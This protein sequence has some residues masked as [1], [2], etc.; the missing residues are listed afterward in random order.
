[1]QKNKLVR[2][3]VVYMALGIIPMASALFLAPVYTHYLKPEEYGIIALAN[4]LQTYLSLLVC[5]S[6]DAAFSRFYFNNYRDKDKTN[7]MLSNTLITILI[8]TVIT[9]A[10][11]YFTGDFLFTILFDTQV[12]KY[13]DLGW[14]ILLTSGFGMCYSVVAIYLRDSEK[15][16]LFSILAIAYFLLLT[17]CTYYGVV[18]A[19]NGAEGSITGKMI[20]TI[21]TIVPFLLYFLMRIGF[22]F[23]IK[24]TMEMLKFSYPLFIYGILAAIFD[25]MDRFFITHYFNLAVLGEYNFAFII[26]SVIGVVIASYQSAVNPPIY[27]MLLDKDNDHSV[28][29]NKMMKRFIWTGL[30]FASLCITLAYFTIHL[31]INVEYFPS[32]P[33]IPLLALSFIPRAYY[34]V[35]SYP[36]FI[37][38][39]TKALP[40]INGI[41][42]IAGIISNILLIPFIG[43]YGIA[44][45]VIIIK[46]VQAGVTL[47]IVKKMNI[48]SSAVFQFRDVNFASLLFALL[49]IFI[50]I[51]PYSSAYYKFIILIPFFIIIFLFLKNNY[52]SFWVKSW[53]K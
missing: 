9:A 32:I 6:L 49:I 24:L 1:M 22:K 2:S 42:I 51:V 36:L 28:Q 8:G 39:K 45:S 16:K 3:T 31:F 47:I 35:W 18:I 20:G 26:A 46:T 21:V 25:T 5:F 10:I 41:S 11:L 40:V 43:V 19:D 7:A 38:N 34:M 50:S 44:V 12:I 4:V 37:E 29:L 17:G 15:L 27:K 33:F 53:S 52:K 13:T 30:I 48:Y 14:Q 23:N